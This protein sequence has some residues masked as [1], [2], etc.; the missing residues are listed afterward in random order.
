MLAVTLYFLISI[1]SFLIAASINVT[2]TNAGLTK[3]LNPIGELVSIL[4]AFF[5][6]KM[7]LVTPLNAQVLVFPMFILVAGVLIAIFLKTLL[8]NVADTNYGICTC[9]D[10]LIAD[11]KDDFRRNLV[12]AGQTRIVLFAKNCLFYIFFA[13][14]TILLAIF[15]SILDLILLYFHFYLYVPGFI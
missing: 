4:G 12:K 5:S 9:L 7:L 8:G 1:A 15:C 14:S 13:L 10:H 2:L 11:V 6:I 3:G